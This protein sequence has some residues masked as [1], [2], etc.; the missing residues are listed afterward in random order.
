MEVRDK[1]PNRKLDA[2]KTQVEE[3]RDQVDL[4]EAAIKVG[5]KPPSGR[6]AAAATASAPPAAA[7]PA[8]LELVG[9]R[10]WMASDA[11]STASHAAMRC[12]ASSAEP[13]PDE[14]AP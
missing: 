4:I 1:A 12:R 3:M 5:F 6:G 13:G 2:L 11:R 10:E 8:T 9:W 7:R 14:A